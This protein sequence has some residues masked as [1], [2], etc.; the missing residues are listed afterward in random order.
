M[1]SEANPTELEA[2]VINVMF[3]LMDLMVA[4]GTVTTPVLVHS[5]DQLRDEMLRRGYP[6][7]AGH[8]MHFSE[9]LA[10]RG[11]QRE[12]AQSLLRAKP[13]GEA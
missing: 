12:Q 13:E 7:S 6:Q 8:M 11:E 3:L 10:R 4:S 2:T 5:L 1:T 9:A